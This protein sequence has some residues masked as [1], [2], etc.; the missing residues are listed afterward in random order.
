MSLVSTT[1]EKADRDSND[2]E[3]HDTLGS[4]DGMSLWVKIFLGMDV[5]ITTFIAVGLSL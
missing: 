5:V 1:D 3:N 2:S 4:T